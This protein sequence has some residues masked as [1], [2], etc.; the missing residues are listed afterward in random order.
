MIPWDGYFIFCIFS[1]FYRDNGFG[2]HGFD[3]EHGFVLYLR[4]RFTYER[5]NPPSFQIIGY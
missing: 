3:I 5:K 1:W 4:R 2:N